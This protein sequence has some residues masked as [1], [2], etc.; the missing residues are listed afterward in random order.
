[1][2]GAPIDWST[3]RLDRLK[4]VWR[5]PTAMRETIAERVGCSYDAAKNKAN[6][7]GLGKRPRKPPPSMLGKPA[8]PAGLKKDAAAI[9]ST[10]DHARAHA[11]RTGSHALISAILRHHPAYAARAG[12]GVLSEVAPL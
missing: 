10:D 7:L 6:E 1:M 3:E 9:A 11:A 2:G 5:D 12:H 4:A 8:G